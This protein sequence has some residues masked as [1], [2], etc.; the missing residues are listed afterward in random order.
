MGKTGNWRRIPY[1][2]RRPTVARIKSRLWNQ[3]EPRLF[4]PRPYGAG[5]TVNF[6]RLLGRARKP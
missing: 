4:V 2:W 1:D 3:D 6:A 5:W